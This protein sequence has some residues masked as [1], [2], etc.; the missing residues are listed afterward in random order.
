MDVINEKDVSEKIVTPALDKIANEI[1]PAIER[2][3]QR[4][5]E[6]AMS[7]VAVVLA[8]GLGALQSTADRLRDG[9]RADLDA[10]DGWTVEIG[11]IRIPPISIRLTKPK[12]PQ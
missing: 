12:E 9:V 3:L 7:R 6:A 11:E 8:D 1:V 10:L 5:V 4:Q 2:A